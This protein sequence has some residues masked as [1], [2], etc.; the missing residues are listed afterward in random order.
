MTNKP[1]S[2]CSGDNC[3]QNYNN[4]CDACH[5]INVDSYNYGACPPK[6]IVNIPVP[7]NS[8]PE[9]I[10][11]YNCNSYNSQ[12][13]CQNSYAPVCGKTDNSVNCLVPPCGENFIN[14][15]EACKSGKISQFALGECKTNIIKIDDFNNNVSIYTGIQQEE[16]NIIPIGN[17]KCYYKDFFIYDGQISCSNLK[18]TDPVCGEFDRSTS[19]CLGGNCHRTYQNSCLACKDGARSYKLGSCLI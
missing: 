11:Y 13:I 4:I 19:G 10:N 6:D 2:I 16:P 3:Y 17:I 18:L 14:E 7:N 12:S 8:N 5:T 1:Y 15:C 9:L